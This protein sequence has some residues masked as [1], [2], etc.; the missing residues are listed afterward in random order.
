MLFGFL[1]KPTRSESICI[2]F[3]VLSSSIPGIHLNEQ[4]E[5]QT[6]LYSEIHFDSVGQFL[7]L[8]FNEISTICNFYFPTLDDNENAIDS[9]N[10]LHLQEFTGKVHV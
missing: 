5:T 8:N 9:I 1:Q 4:H 2:Y 6:S 10:C 7:H 3:E